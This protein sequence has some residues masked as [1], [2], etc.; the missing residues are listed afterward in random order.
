LA[1]AASKDQAVHGPFRGATG[2]ASVISVPM[3]PG[4]IALIRMLEPA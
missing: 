3:I 1:V 4:Q 2:E